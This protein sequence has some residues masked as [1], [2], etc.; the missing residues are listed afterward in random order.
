MRAGKAA[1][2]LRMQLSSCRTFS[3][4]ELHFTTL[5]LEAPLLLLLLPPPPPPLLSVTELA[6]KL[7]I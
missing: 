2:F 6:Q 5:L 4:E 1:E 7:G 3:A